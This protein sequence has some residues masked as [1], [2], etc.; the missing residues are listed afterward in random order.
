MRMMGVEMVA[1]MGHSQMNIDS[2][3]PTQF[4]PVT[5]SGAPELEPVLPFL[6]A[7]QEIAKGRLDNAVT[8]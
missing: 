7:H 6:H 3:M 5:Y 1:H 4:I 8:G 2:G